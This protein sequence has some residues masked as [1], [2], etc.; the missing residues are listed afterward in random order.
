M[1]T[2]QAAVTLWALEFSF[3]KKGRQLAMSS[4]RS[5]VIIVVAMGLAPVTSC[6]SE[7]TPKAVFVIIDG[8]PADVI[9]RTSTPAIDEVAAAG[10]YT[11]AYVGGETGGESE[12][13]TS[14]AI[15]YQN[16]LTG[17]WANKHNVYSNDIVAPNY[18]YWDI[19]RIA[20]NHDAS[21]QT[22]VFSTWE[23]NRTKL[24]GDGLEQAGGH[25][26]D[27][28]ADGFEN[29]T[30]RFPHDPLSNYIRNIDELV[31]LE[32]STYIRS[33]GPD[34]AWVYLQYTDDV[35][36]AV[37]DSQL[38]TWA[39]ELMDKRVGGIWDAVKERAAQ[40]NE[41]WL[42]VVTTDHGRDAETGR[43]HGKQSERERTT[44]ISTN[45]TR[46]N[47]H[48][49]DLPGIVDILPSIVTHMGLTMPENIQAQLD[50]QS[51]ID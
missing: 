47:D 1:T 20:K 25:K 6:A 35:G 38:Q 48:F 34:L 37:G 21:L 42:I 26:I 13:P 15:G 51:F 49:N 31:V 28:Y 14:S 46:L 50:G 33:D 39:V 9:E 17:T 10:G 12:S 7:K 29:D 4:L 2:A 43:S 45:S 8:I 30:E 36:H 41:D 16:L 3:S 44:W 23:D 5:I 32:A 11:R 40:Y 19:F 22:A 27:H 24:I 18:D